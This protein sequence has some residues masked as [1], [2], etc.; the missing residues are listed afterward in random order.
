MEQEGPKHV[1]YNGFYN[2]ILTLTQLC[3][4]VGLDYSNQ[5]QC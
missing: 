1:G 5:N 4:F 2:I 3:A